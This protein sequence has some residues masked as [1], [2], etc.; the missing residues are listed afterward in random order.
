MASRDDDDYAPSRIRLPTLGQNGE[1]FVIWKTQLKS[2]ITGMGKARY[3]NGRATE[4][5]K[6]IL[7]DGANDAA[8]A[9]HKR[10]L[11]TYDEEMD[12]WEKHNEKIRT[13]FFATIH[14]THK[15]R[16]ANHTSARESWNMLCKMY[17]HQGEL[18]TQSLVDRMHALKCPEGDRDPRPT[19]DQLDLLIANHASAG[20]TPNYSFAFSATD[21]ATDF[22]KIEEAGIVSRGSTALLDSGANRHYCPSRK[23]F[24]EYRTI[25]AVPI[26]SA[27]NRTFFATGCGKVPVT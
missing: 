23:R 9:A 17:E 2:Q 21:V 7:A 5:V 6:P 12:E 26:R 24:I 11:E 22:T 18:H 3:I 16:I 15:I 27:D 14:E 19:L 13:L 20:G 4:P 8:R 25:D 10:D 1:N